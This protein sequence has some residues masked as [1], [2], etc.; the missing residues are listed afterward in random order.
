MPQSIFAL[1]R[2]VY[3]RFPEKMRPAMKVGYYWCVIRLQA[4]FLR[5]R[6][7]AGQRVEF[8]YFDI[9]HL[10]KTELLGP[11]S[12]EVLVE[13]CCSLVSPGTEQAIL[14]GLPG[15]RHNFPFAPGYSGAGIV[16]KIGKKV[17]GLKVGQPVAGM[18]HHASHETLAPNRVFAIPAGVSYEEASFIV[19]G[20]IALQGTR[21]A[22]IVPGDRV[23]VVGQGLI[24]Q[25]CCKFAR[26]FGAA[27]VIAVASS[28]NRQQLSLRAG[29]DRFLALAEGIQALR[30]IAADAVIEA[31]GTPQAIVAAFECA[32]VKGR[33]SIVGSS[34][35]LGRDLDVW[36]LM[37][38]KGLT[39]TGAHSSTLP[40]T[41]PSR[42]RWTF[43]QEGRLFLELLQTGRLRVADLI[44]WRARPAECNAVYETLANGARDQVG[45]L[46]DWK[47]GE[48]PLALERTG[49]ADAVV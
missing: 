31:A 29:A 43:H 7:Y 24:G 34:R 28:P 41:D 47:R 12:D 2:A 6:V 22:R 1:L 17:T 11:A 35:G 18:L 25:L 37:Q 16:R 10:E 39:V 49:R 20:I 14:C 32:S 38:K 19:L 33:V 8:L 46:F 21:K 42:S 45:I 15:M 9:A 4:V 5:R 36:Q 48:T 44:T 13:T 3:L 27:Q 40:G 23:A 26:L 30:N